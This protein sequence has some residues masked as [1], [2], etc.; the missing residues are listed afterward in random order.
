MTKTEAREIVRR[1]AALVL[2][3]DFYGDFA[4]LHDAA[5]GRFPTKESDPDLYG[6]RDELDEALWE[7]IEELKD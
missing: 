7:L 3:K 2:E 6:S 5:V 4:V 1:T